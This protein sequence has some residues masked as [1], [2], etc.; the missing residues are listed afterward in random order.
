MAE[1]FALRSA[2]SK[3]ESAKNLKHLGFQRYDLPFIVTSLTAAEGVPTLRRT[4][5]RD[6]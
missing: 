1:L 4:Q 3:A 2:T 5:R 6:E